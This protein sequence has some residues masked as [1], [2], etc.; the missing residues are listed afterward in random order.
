MQKNEELIGMLNDLIRIN[1]DRFEGYKKALKLTREIDQDLR[2]LFYKMADESRKNTSALITQ[3]L[4]LR[5]MEVT[6]AGFT[7]N[8]Y[9]EWLESKQEFSAIDRHG[10]LTYCEYMEVMVQRAY[11]SAL[12]IEAHI[13]DN[14]SHTLKTQ[15]RE[16]KGSNHI[17]KSYH[18]I[19]ESIAA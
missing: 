1:N 16:M 13:P 11:D 18:T 14:I 9:Q 10:I 3:V 12:G 4:R 19:Y 6:G 2:I 15:K 17:V 7:G 8:V 5:S